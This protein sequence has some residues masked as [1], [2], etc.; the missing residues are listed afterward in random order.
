[1]E[2]AERV[3]VTVL[4]DHVD[5][6]CHGGHV[7]KMHLSRCMSSVVREVHMKGALMSHLAFFS[8]IWEIH[9]YQTAFL[10]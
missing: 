3:V 2:R 6:G 9:V 1:M 4:K 10:H 7:W 8:H 5:E